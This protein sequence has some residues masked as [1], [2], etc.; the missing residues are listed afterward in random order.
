MIDL[1]DEIAQVDEFMIE[2][3]LKAVLKRYAELFPD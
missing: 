3:I 1:V 2:G